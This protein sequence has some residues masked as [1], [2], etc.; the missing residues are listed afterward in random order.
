VR[1]LYLLRSVQ[2]PTVMRGALRHYHFL[3][4]LS[5]RHSVTLVAL[6]EGPV[7][8]QARSELDALTRRLVIVPVEPPRRG[9]NRLDPAGGVARL[10]RK[11]RI[12]RAVSRMRGK[13]EELVRSHPFDVVLVHGKRIASVVRSLDG[14][15]RVVDVCD[16]SSLRRRELLRQAR[17]WAAPWRAAGY[18]GA[19]HTER[20]LTQRTSHL[21]FISQRDR[22]AVMAGSGS[23]RVVPN[24]LDL[25]YWTRSAEFRPTP[26]S[27]VFTGVMD[28]A[29]NEDAARILVEEV[30]PRV[31]SKRP[32]AELV[33]AGRDPSAA[34]TALGATTPS[35]TV[36]GFVEDLRPWLAGGEVYAAPI[37]AASGLQNKILEAMAME[38]PVV[39]TPIVAAGL[40]VEGGDEPPV[41]AVDG[42]EAT[43]S[44]ILE[45]LADSR[46]RESLSRAG[47]RYVER[48]FDWVAGA[49]ALE[50][51]C[52]EAAGEAAHASAAESHGGAR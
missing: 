28:Y 26:G 52:A 44:A 25:E 45:L 15:P 21:A 7:P 43:A 41:V 17:P 19:R 22:D 40:R 36:T 51:L 49:R 8:A 31:K 14:L 12:R 37:R 11:L 24:G 34:L 10:G 2:H 50:A 35:V 47:R 38:V 46:R 39:T 29:P 13:V 3:R 42:P 30:L 18:L 16:A 4:E 33:L 1:I 23:A 6:A 32:K 48:H 9:P 20:W 5:L 27:V